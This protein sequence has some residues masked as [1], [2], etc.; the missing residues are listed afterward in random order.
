MGLTEYINT[1]LMACG[2]SDVNLIIYIIIFYLNE[3]VFDK[4]K[5][6]IDKSKIVK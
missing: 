3:V 1:I 5:I 4:F 2:L 6:Y